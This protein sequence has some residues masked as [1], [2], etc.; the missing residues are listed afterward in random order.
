[1]TRAHNAAMNAVVVPVVD[2]A[3]D[4]HGGALFSAL[5]GVVGGTLNRARAVVTPDSWHG[6]TK[7][8]QTMTGAAALGNARPYAQ[9]SS[10]LNRESSTQDAGA[11]AIFR[12]RMMRSGS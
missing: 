11:A 1:M 8:L 6:W 10:E 2:Y 5:A 4:P 7:P 9:S 12:S 3:P